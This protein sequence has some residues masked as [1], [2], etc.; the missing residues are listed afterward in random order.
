[1]VLVGGILK[2]L[3]NQN[4]VG[5]RNEGFSGRASDTLTYVDL[6]FVRFRGGLSDFR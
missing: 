4:I 1:M 2:G 6:S 5:K 3:K